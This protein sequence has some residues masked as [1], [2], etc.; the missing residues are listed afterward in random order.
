MP[1][2]E[3]DSRP[4]TL[5]PKHRDRNVISAIVGVIGFFLVWGLV[6]SVGVGGRAGATFFNLPSALMVVV[7]PMTILMAV[8]GWAGIIDAF[9]WIA[10]EPTPGKT[11]EDAVT[12]FQLAAAFSLATGLLGTLVGLMMMLNNLSDPA[13][14]GPGMAVSLLTQLYG[15]FI[16]VICISMGAYVARRHRCVATA[17]AVGFRAASVA[18]ITTIA[19]TFVVLVS[20]CILM[21]SLAPA[22]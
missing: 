16:A 2:I 15:V 18:G 10:R 17:K 22:L 7:V 20:F 13:G 4:S 11:A 1:S 21:L 19:G 9:A 8:Y 3:S 5:V 14:I 6:L 12:F